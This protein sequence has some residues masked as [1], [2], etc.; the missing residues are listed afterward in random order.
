[1]VAAAVDA[2]AAMPDGVTLWPQPATEP[3]P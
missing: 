2:L 3:Q 1:V